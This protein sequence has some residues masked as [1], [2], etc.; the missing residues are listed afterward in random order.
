MDRAQYD[1]FTQRLRA[2]LE[3]DGRVLGLVAMGSM[4]GELPEAD[5]YSDHDFFV[6]VRTGEQERMRT[7][8]S[9]L[10]DAGEIVL[11]FR[12]TAHGVKVVYR[13][14]HLL[15]FAVFDPD[16]LQLARVNRYRTLL[17]RAGIEERMRALRERTAREQRPPDRTWLWGQFLTALLVGTG[18]FR[19]GERL[20]GRTMLLAA[21]RYLAQLSGMPSDSLDPVRRFPDPRGLVDGALEQPVPRGALS[22]LRIASGLDG[23]PVEAARAIEPHLG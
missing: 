17:D 23:F 11:A 1:A 15:E 4:S 18:R 3:A 19:R 7:D 16:E 21:A 2:S 6:V 9:W 5:A 20:S 22:L 14:G 10:P 8:L 13:S 12:E